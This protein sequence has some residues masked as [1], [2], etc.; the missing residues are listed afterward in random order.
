MSGWGSWVSGIAKK[1]AGE[2]A[3]FGAECLDSVTSIDDG[4]EETPQKQRQQ[5]PSDDTATAAAREA[6]PKAAGSAETAKPGAA[7]S[8]NDAPHGDEAHA[9]RPKVSKAAQFLFGVE[10]DVEEDTSPSPATTPAPKGKHVDPAAA[11]GEASPQGW[12]PKELGFAKAQTDTLLSLGRQLVDRGADAA[13]QLLP[14]L[15]DTP[16]RASEA[17]DSPA[18]GGRAARA[19]STGPPPRGEP[20]DD[21]KLARGA[22]ELARR[23]KDDAAANAVTD[24]AA[25]ELESDTVCDFDVDLAED[26]RPDVAWVEATHAGRR[27]MLARKDMAAPLSDTTGAP[28]ADAELVAALSTLPTL[29]ADG[30]AAIVDIVL[31]ELSDT[32]VYGDHLAPKNGDDDDDDAAEL[33]WWRRDATSHPLPIA[34]DASVDAVFVP[35][36]RCYGANVRALVRFAQCEVARGITGLCGLASDAHH[37]AKREL[38]AQAKAVREESLAVRGDCYVAVAPEFMRLEE[39]LECVASLFVVALRR[40]AV[41]ADTA[42]SPGASKDAAAVAVTADEDDDATDANADVT[43]APR[44]AT[45]E[46]PSSAAE[47]GEEDAEVAQ[48]DEAGDAVEVKPATV[49]D[50]S[51]DRADDEATAATAVEDEVP[52]PAAPVAADDAADAAPQQ[53]EEAAAVADDAADAPRAATPEAKAEAPAEVPSESP[54]PAADDAAPVVDDAAA[55]AVDESKGGK[56]GRGG[57]RRGKGRGK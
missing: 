1:A 18:T 9:R 50:V 41:P 37:Y 5:Q 17:G 26:V 29:A 24:A 12:L 45:P 33:S 43:P 53:Q 3:Q 39:A 44:A 22:A 54:A 19:A 48:E 10:G 49:A 42:S 52:V 14:D 8:S 30:T 23:Q 25:A 35:A 7:A 36:A 20:L 40:R 6:T 13:L 16:T 55:P 46:A 2:V 32:F 27:I 4:S 28:L 21:L 47:A 34:A 11:D 31:S 51:R 56:G 15:E 57:R 38:P